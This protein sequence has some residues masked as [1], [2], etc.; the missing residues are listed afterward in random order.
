[1]HEKSAAQSHHLAA[2][3]PHNA[4]HLKRPGCV[5]G[6]VLYEGVPDVHAT[7]GLPADDPSPIRREINRIDTGNGSRSQRAHLLHQILSRP[8][9]SH[10]MRKTPG[11]KQTSLY[12]PKCNHTKLLTS[13]PVAT[14]QICTQ[15]APDPLTTRFMSG[16]KETDV[17]QAEPPIVRTCHT[18]LSSDQFQHRSCPKTPSQQTHH[19]DTF[20]L[21]SGCSHWRR[22]SPRS[23][24]ARQGTR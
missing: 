12:H 2:S 15:P 11:R 6:P 17:T 19:P 16:E 14:F 24:H 22:P 9:P 18:N 20:T 10:I 1:M 13:I 5:P 7:V 21:V 4:A 3:R 8:L 23:S